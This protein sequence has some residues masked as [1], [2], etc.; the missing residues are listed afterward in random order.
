MPSIG[1]SEDALADLARLVEFL[2]QNDPAE[3]DATVGLIARA[4][5]ILA[6]HP[7]VGRSAGGLRR[8]LVISRGRTGYIALYTYDP[9]QDRIVVHGV[10]HQR[11]AGFDE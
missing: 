2:A 3:A 11:E 5:E 6:D 8:E 1:Y 10:R 7:L 9:A 4:I